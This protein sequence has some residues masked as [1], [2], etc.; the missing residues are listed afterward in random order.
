M[1]QASEGAAATAS[2]EPAT[3]PREEPRSSQSQQ[4]HVD[5][6]PPKTIRRIKSSPSIRRQIRE[7]APSPDSDLGNDGIYNAERVSPTLGTNSDDDGSVEDLSSLLATFP[8][9]PKRRALRSS[10][11]GDGATSHS[12]WPAPQLVPIVEVSSIGSARTSQSLARLSAGPERS[13]KLIHL[14]QSYHSIHPVQ[15]SQTSQAPCVPRPDS[16]T[17]QTYPQYTNPQTE[18]NL[19]SGMHES[20]R[21]KDYSSSSESVISPALDGPAYPN[22]PK[23]TPPEPVHTPPGLAS[24]GSREATQYRLEQGPFLRRVFRRIRPRPD[25]DLDDAGHDDD[26]VITT[27]PSVAPIPLSLRQSNESATAW[28]EALSDTMESVGMA[29][30]IEPLIDAATKQAAPLPSG[31]FTSNVPGSLA[32]ADDGTYV[33]GQFGARTSGHG[34]GSRYLGSH[35]LNR[36]NE[37]QEVVSEINKA[38]E[39]ADDFANVAADVAHQVTIEETSGIYGPLPTSPASPM[40]RRVPM[41]SAPP[42][43]AL[44][45]AT[46]TELRAAIERSLPHLRYTRSQM[47][48]Y[49]PDQITMR[50]PATRYP[51]DSSHSGTQSRRALEIFRPVQESPTHDEAGNARGD[52]AGQVRRWYTSAS[53]KVVKACRSLSCT[54]A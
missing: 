37:I 45:P 43:R 19:M 8:D 50:T 6:S 18:E 11:S 41:S 26:P 35:P 44:N 23:H 3:P 4:G 17:I 46:E 13:S 34:V 20:E 7:Q 32:L 12:R 42:A 30:M 47:V 2:T 39:R 15:M 21:P 36:L 31:L 51:T 1:E 48:H 9:T 25:H 33:R 40:A 38:C 54:S 53:T 49:N 29:R 16:P 28:A 5:N 14:D 22:M 52:T 24:F 10:E 27:I